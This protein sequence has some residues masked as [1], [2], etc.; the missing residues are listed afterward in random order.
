M[1][2]QINFLNKLDETEFLAQVQ[3]DLLVLD[4][5]GKPVRSVA[6]DEGR[7]FLLFALRAFDHRDD[8]KGGA[9]HGKVCGMGL[10]PGT[11]ERCTKR[12]QYGLTATGDRRRSSQGRHGAPGMDKDDRGILD[13][14]GD[15]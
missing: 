2:W 14:R 8:C 7:V 13:V 12:D 11:R 3:Y 5:D 10:R 1:K 6:R 9:R 4:E 15:L